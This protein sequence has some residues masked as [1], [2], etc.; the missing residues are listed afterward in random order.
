M[1]LFDEANCSRQNEDILFH[2]ATSS[3]NY[4]KPAANDLGQKYHKKDL[5]SGYY[6]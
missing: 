2:S 1:A 3:F 6:F 5:F 4:F